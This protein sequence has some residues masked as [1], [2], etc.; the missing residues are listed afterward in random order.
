[1]SS[2]ATTAGTYD[3]AS[4]VNRLLAFSIDMAVV[5]AI[6]LLK[7]VLALLG[8][9]FY[10]VLGPMFLQVIDSALTLLAF[11]YFLFCDALPKGQS[12]GK[13]LCRI[14]VVGFPYPTT[15]TIPQSFLRNACKL[16]FSPLD[17]FLVLF[18]LRRRL[19]DMLAKTIV[20][21]A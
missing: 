4:R 16:L 17:G 8:L 12:L 3:L 5:V 13:R 11:G 14:T 6:L 18:G 15:C 20:I 10:D 9:R 7:H 21:N 2:S 19:G 1:M